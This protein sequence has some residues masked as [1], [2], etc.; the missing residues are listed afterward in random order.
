MRSY[1]RGTKAVLSKYLVARVREAH[2][3]SLAGNVKM[4]ERRPRISAREAR[5]AF[6]SDR[7][8]TMRSRG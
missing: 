6:G 7:G 2:F 1:A 5:R 3:C 8:C 4:T